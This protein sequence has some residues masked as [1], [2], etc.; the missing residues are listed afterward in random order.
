M[1]NKL[2]VSLH[3]L[4]AV[5]FTLMDYNFILAWIYVSRIFHKFNWAPQE[6]EGNMIWNY[7]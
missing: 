6:V 7:I 1:R 4:N 5:L 3:Y 2:V